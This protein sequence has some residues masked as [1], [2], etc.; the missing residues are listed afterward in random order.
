MNKEQDA[1]ELVE[2]GVASD[3]TRGAHG[4]P[5]EPVG[6]QPIGLSDAD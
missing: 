1:L 4:F 2:L 6:L 3:E 5:Q